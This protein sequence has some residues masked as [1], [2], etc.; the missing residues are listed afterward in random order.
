VSRSSAKIPFWILMKVPG[1][2]GDIG[3]CLLLRHLWARHAA[4][5]RALAAYGF[6]LASILVSS[7]H[8][9]TDA[10]CAFLCLLCAYLGEDARRPFWSGV[11]LAGALNVKFV[12]FIL[13]PPALVIHTKWRS[14]LKFLAGG[15]I[16]IIPFLPFLLNGRAEF[17]RN[18]ISYSPIKD[19][20]GIPFLAR[21]SS[22]NPFFGPTA[23]RFFDW[24]VDSGRNIILLLVGGLS[25]F[26]FLSRKFNLYELFSLSFIAFLVFAPGFGVQYT[27]Y[28]C[29]VLFAASLRWGIRY[30][31]LAGIFIGTVYLSWLGPGYPLTSIFQSWYPWPAPL[32]GLLAWGYMLKVG[33][34]IIKGALARLP[35]SGPLL[36]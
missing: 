20:W 17:V 9:N 7:Y 11:A 33:Y 5:P 13:I 35:R 16:G 22:E 14:W 18:T 4:G 2:A 23:G 21:L 24:Y 8:C 27:V 30:A 34:R 15:A 19:N 36:T 25:A 1:L 28:L 32:L 26:A 31:F 3:S 6:S 10:L 29:P 12:P